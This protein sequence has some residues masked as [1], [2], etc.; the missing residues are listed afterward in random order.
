MADTSLNTVNGQITSAAP[1]AKEP[2][3]AGVVPSGQAT[4]TASSRVAA[5][6][7]APAALDANKT[8]T[9]GADTKAMHAAPTLIT[10]AAVASPQSKLTELILS[11]I[12][13]SAGKEVTEK[14]APIVA[15]V[16]D[17]L[18]EFVNGLIKPSSSQ[19]PAVNASTQTQTANATGATT[20]VTVNPDG[21]AE[22]K[23]PETQTAN[24]GGGV[25]NFLKGIF[26]G[27]DATAKKEA[28]PAVPAPAAVP[29]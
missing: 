17:A 3:A 21:K 15:K 19:T 14:V 11:L 24:T 18:T 28:A 1:A 5:T 29:A 12:T 4:V 20:E 22:T 10:P 25:M 23:A 13:S 27:G 9:A 8:S 6:P 7:V 2:V 26:G 16:V